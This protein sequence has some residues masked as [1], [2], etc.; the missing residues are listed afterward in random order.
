MPKWTPETRVVTMDS[1][2]SEV[3]S[4]LGQ[5]Y[6]EAPWSKQVLDKIVPHVEAAGQL[7]GRELA[8]EMSLPPSRTAEDHMSDKKLHTQILHLASTLPKGNMTRKALLEMLSSAGPNPKGSNWKEKTNPN[9]WVWTGSADEPVF[10]VFEKTDARIG[11][12]YKLQILLPNGDMFQTY[13]Q[14]TDAQ[15]WFV[16]AADLFKRWNSAA[17]FDLSQTPEKWNKVN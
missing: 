1:L 16:R 2:L 13:G 17:G 6:R 3:E 4:H 7:V 15:A 10:M 12:F 5:M 9:R 8:R 14:K 11:K